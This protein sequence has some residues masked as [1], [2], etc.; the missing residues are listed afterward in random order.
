M[1]NG[2]RAL[3]PGDLEGDIG[4]G[5][6]ALGPDDTLGN[7][8]LRNQECAR[9][10]LCFQASEQAQREGNPRFGREHGMTGREDEAEEIV[11]DHVVVGLGDGGVEIRHGHPLLGFERATE[12]LMLAREPFAPA[13]PVDGTPFRDRHEPRA[14][15]VRHARFRPPL[16]RNDQGVLRE[17]LGQPDVAHHPRETCDDPGRLDPPD[18]VDNAMCVGSRHIHSRMY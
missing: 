11:F 9:D 5:K 3:P 10:L 8:R 6:G 4:L 17:L 18:C 12:L 7:G 1:T 2:M 16:E 13:Q 15:V 14:R